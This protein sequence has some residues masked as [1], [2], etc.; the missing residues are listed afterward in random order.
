[1]KDWYIVIFT[2]EAAK[3]FNKPFCLAKYHEGM[4]NG[5]ENT[6][7][8]SDAF[9]ILKHHI[10]RVITMKTAWYFLQDVLHSKRPD[11]NINDN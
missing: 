3:L 6:L 11:L 9:P 7:F 8:N 1:M 10:D 5:H 4:H 2:E